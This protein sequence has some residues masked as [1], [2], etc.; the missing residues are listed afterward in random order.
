MIFFF[1]RRKTHA[2]K[3][4]SSG[5]GSVGP[6]TA[7]SWTRSGW[8][9]FFGTAKIKPT[10]YNNFDFQSSKNDAF[11]INE[12]GLTGGHHTRADYA[13]VGKLRV[14]PGRSK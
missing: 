8:Y 5:A 7:S 13:W 2:A 11:I 9:R 14:T 4:S 10:F 12:G 3:H 6:D 1:D